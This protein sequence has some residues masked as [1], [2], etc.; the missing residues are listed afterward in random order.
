MKASDDRRP[1]RRAQEAP[2]SEALHPFDK[3][4][5]VLLV[6]LAAFLDAALLLQLDQRLGEGSTVWVGEVKRYFPAPSSITRHWSYTSSDRDRAPP[7]HTASALARAR[8]KPNPRT[9]WIHLLALLTRKSMPTSSRSNGT[10]PKVLEAP[11]ERAP[12]AY[13][14]CRKFVYNSGRVSRFL[15]HPVVHT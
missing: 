6:S 8:M 1:V 11:R 2:E 14:S 13:R 12:P 7:S 10:P 4:A 3:D 9:P 15:T 5:V